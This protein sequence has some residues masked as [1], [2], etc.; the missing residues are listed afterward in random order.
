MQK[1]LNRE[2]VE[3]ITHFLKENDVKHYDVQLEMIDHFA[4]SIEEQWD[5]YP[6]AW[7]FKLK[8]LDIYNHIG[9]KGFE[10]IVAEKTSAANRK[11]YKYAFSLVKQFFKL[12][13]II[14]SILVIVFLFELLRKPETQE[15]L[16]KMGLLIPPIAVMI[17]TASTLLF[18]WIKNNKRLLSLEANALLFLLPNGLTSMVHSLNANPDAFPENEW[19]LFGMAILVFLQVLFCTGLSVF[20]INAYREIGRYFPKY[21]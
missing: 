20:I 16:F 18:N 4:T 6:S 5:T 19:F 9:K 1:Q 10:K 11:A 12:P 8:I 13:Q 7:N 3:Q 21:S 17:I 15:G 2:E 14:L